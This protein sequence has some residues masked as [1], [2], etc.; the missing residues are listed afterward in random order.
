MPLYDRPEQ[1]PNFRCF[2][3]VSLYFVSD[4]TSRFKI[5]DNLANLERIELPLKDLEAFVLPLHHRNVIGALDRSRTCKIQFLKLKRI[6]IPS[7][8]QYFIWRPRQESNLYPTRQ[9]RVTLIPL[10]Y[11]DKLICVSLLSSTDDRLVATLRQFKTTRRVNN[12][13]QLHCNMSSE[14]TQN[15]E[16]HKGL[17]PLYDFRLLVWKTSA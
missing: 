9:K 15:L 13:D 5:L 2:G 11:E 1:L 17:E 10:C 14:L 3:I 6:P 16:R 12:D 7:Q 8:A 4:T